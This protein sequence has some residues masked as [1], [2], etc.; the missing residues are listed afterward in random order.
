MDELDTPIKHNILIDYRNKHPVLSILFKKKDFIMKNPMKTVQYAID[1]FQDRWPEDATELFDDRQYETEP[2]IINAIW[3]V[4]HF[5]IK[6]WP[7]LEKK[8]IKYIVWH[9]KDRWL[10]GENIINQSRQLNDNDDI[11]Y[12]WQ[13]SNIHINIETKKTPTY[14]CSTT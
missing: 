14:V 13:H 6:R 4:E 7:E 11:L 2:Y 1:V 9:L 5:E 8:N 12:A 10:E 3:Y